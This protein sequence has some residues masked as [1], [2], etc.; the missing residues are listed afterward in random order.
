MRSV[1]LRALLPAVI[2]LTMF[3][4]H[5]STVATVLGDI[6]TICSDASALN[7]AIVAFPNT[8][9]SLVGAL[10]IHTY[11]VNVDTAIRTTETDIKALTPLP[12]SEAD[13]EA[14]CNALLACIG[15]ILET[16]FHNFVSK[17]PSAFTALPVGGLPALI[18]SDLTNVVT[19]LDALEDALATPCLSTVIP[20]LQAALNSVS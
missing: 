20:V 14:I 12:I 11:A 13:S 2:S 16:A 6:N 3:G 4:V 7:T 1:S 19:D 15:P 8:G 9:G 5:G 10:T 18:K 17:P